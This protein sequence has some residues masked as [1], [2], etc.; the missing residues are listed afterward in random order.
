MI[1][2]EVLIS[3]SAEISWNSHV[4]QFELKRYI[5]AEWVKLVL[6]IKIYQNVTFLYIEM[7]NILLVNL[8]QCFK[9]LIENNERC[10]LIERLRENCEVMQWAILAVLKYHVRLFFIFI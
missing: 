8:L 5:A 3:K 10:W 1:D 6:F 9:D 2:S 7:Q 4:S